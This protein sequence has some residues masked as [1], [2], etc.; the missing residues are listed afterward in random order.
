MSEPSE[1]DRAHR[2]HLAALFAAADAAIAA[3]FAVL[4]AA[5]WLKTDG[6][7]GKAPLLA[8]GHLEAHRDGQL[9]RRQLADP[10]RVPAGVPAA[11]EVVVGFVPGSGGHLVADCD[12]K[13]GKVGLDTLRALVAQH[14]DFVTSVWR[15]PSGGV[16]VLLR[17]PPG[18]C[19][20]NVS[21]WPGIDVR[22]DGG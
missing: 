19:Y 11:F 12:V 13:A 5:T 20:S 22:A 18:A 2:D 4:P 6:A 16:N 1:D 14:G 3:D 8:H 15:S 17:K 10:P 21:P 7:L 9:I